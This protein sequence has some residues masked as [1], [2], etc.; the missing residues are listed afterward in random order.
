MSEGHTHDSGPTIR[1][2]VLGEVTVIDDDGEHRVTRPMPAKLLSILAL[3]PRR[4]HF[5]R[6]LYRQIACSYESDDSDEEA[7]RRSKVKDY[8]WKLREVSEA[9]R[10]AIE[11]Q[12]LK[13]E[14]QYRLNLPDESIDIHRIP[15]LLREARSLFKAGDW[16]GSLSLSQDA[17]RLCGGKEMMA[18][19]S[20]DPEEVEPDC[21]FFEAEAM[22]ITGQSAHLLQNGAEARRAKRG[23][24][25]LAERSDDPD[26]WD[27]YVRMVAAIE[28][29]EGAAAAWTEGKEALGQQGMELPQGFSE[30]AE[31]IRE[32]PPTGSA[33]AAAG[34]VTPADPSFP[35]SSPLP[36]GDFVR[37]S[38]TEIGEQFRAVI[39]AIDAA[40]WEPEVIFGINRGGAILGAMLA[41][42]YR[43]DVYWPVHV[44]CDSAKPEQLTAS[45]PGAPRTPFSRILLVDEAYRAGRHAP[46]ARDALVRRYR[47]ADVKY[48][49]FVKQFEPDVDPGHPARPPDFFGAV[50]VTAGFTFPWDRS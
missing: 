48:A 46:V 47:A 34:P 24:R 6:S 15:G 33:A 8:V 12:G 42:Q 13:E 2:R 30:L 1:V 43:H 29:R 14:L 11:Q 22:A 19:R 4:W 45:L 32:L 9:F 20:C 23:L 17:K 40:E 3:T 28:G 35:A 21:V 39:M 31:W 25:D 7:H 10:P 26:V 44:L 16:A 37:Y 27:L 36:T 50:S 49:V 41:K 38:F 5:A 18:L